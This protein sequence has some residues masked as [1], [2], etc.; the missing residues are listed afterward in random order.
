MT[1]TTACAGWPIRSKSELKYGI[2]DGNTTLKTMEYVW[3]GNFCGLPGLTIPVGFVGAEGSEKDGEEAGEEVEGRIPVGMMGMGEW[4]T[5]E[6]LLS[7]GVDCEN[8]GGDRL[9][10][11]PGWVDVVGRAREEMDE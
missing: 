3:M 1:P 9:G 4:T 8:V 7:W 6:E 5:E 10:R 2:S 11:P